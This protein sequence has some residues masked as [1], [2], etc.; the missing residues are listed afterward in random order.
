M[1]RRLLL[2]LLSPLLVAVWLGNLAWGGVGVLHAGAHLVV[3]RV[4]GIPVEAASL[5]VGPA[6]VARLPWRLSVLPG[7]FVR[8]SLLGVPAW[9]VGAYL[10]AGPL[11]SLVS[12]WLV[13]WGAFTIQG[14]RGVVVAEPL[15]DD[16]LTVGEILSGSPAETAGFAVGDTVVSVGGAAVERWSEVPDRLVS[17]PQTIRVVRDGAPVDL[18]V[19]PLEVE[20]RLVLG[21]ARPPGPTS[22]QTYGPTEAAGRASGVVGDIFGGVARLFSGRPTDALGGPVAIFRS[23]PS[24]PGPDWLMI[25]ALLVATRGLVVGVYNLLPLPFSDVLTGLDQVSRRVR[26]RPLP[27]DVANVGCGAMLLALFLVVF[28]MD[29]FR[30]LAL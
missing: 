30:V 1:T 13:L 7:A 11:F 23:A 8:P 21:V 19:T 20:D 14:A 24:N 18:V 3:A 10:S 29:V 25:V 27:L 2:V 6:I 28:L 26:G 9:K 12:A 22:T 16:V 17:G 5:G 15:P 4:L